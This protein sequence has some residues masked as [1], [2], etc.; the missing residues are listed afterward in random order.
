MKKE[1]KAE[2]IDKIINELVILRKRC[3]ISKNPK[4]KKDFSKIQDICIEKLDYLIK[5]R[6]R[7]YKG[8]SNYDDLCQ[9]ARLALYLALHSYEPEKG[10]FFWW[11]NKYIKTKISREANRHS[12][13]KIPLKHTKLIQP[14]KV[15]QLPI[16][17]DNGFNAF[18][19]LSQNESDTIIRNA[20]KKLPKNQREVIELHYEM[21][22][23]KQNPNSIV[24]ICDK[25]NITRMNCLKLLN[26]AKKTLKINL[27]NN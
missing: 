19:S 7:R 6:T 20:V 23:D 5:A 2:E 9:D 26:E 13:I 3:K 27:N 10:N 18:E 4:L 24:K 15:S 22:S 12:T 25:L 11:A 14:Y 8:F 17:I 16:I 1:T 21:S